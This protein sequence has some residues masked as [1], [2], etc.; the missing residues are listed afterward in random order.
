M[1]V[2]P[3]SSAG[4]GRV[5]HVTYKPTAIPGALPPAKTWGKEPPK[6]LEEKIDFIKKQYPKPLNRAYYFRVDEEAEWY[7]YVTVS[8]NAILE[9]KKELGFDDWG[10]FQGEGE[11]PTFECVEYDS[12]DGKMFCWCELTGELLDGGSGSDIE[13]TAYHLAGFVWRRENRFQMEEVDWREATR[14]L[15]LLQYGYHGGSE[16]DARKLIELIATSCFLETVGWNDTGLHAPGG[17]KVMEL[18]CLIRMFEGLKT[19]DAHPPSSSN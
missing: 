12:E 13:H 4:A 2:C 5:A 8:Y 10:I 6:T 19:E 16:S 9:T 14:F 11:E 15:E 3:C 1:T 17:V 7:D 18:P